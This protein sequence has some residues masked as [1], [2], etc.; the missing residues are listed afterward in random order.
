MTGLTND[1]A[2]IPVQKAGM[3]ANVSSEQKRFGDR[4]QNLSNF[5]LVHPQI[6]SLARIIKAAVH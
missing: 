1:R 5:S 4:R 6:F 2:E 3:L